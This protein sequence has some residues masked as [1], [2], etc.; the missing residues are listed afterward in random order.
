[1]LL[2]QM[3]LYFN[4]FIG[5]WGLTIGHRVSLSPLIQ[6]GDE[7]DDVPYLRSYSDYLLNSS[8]NI[9]IFP[10][11][12]YVLLLEC[13]PEKW[14]N[15]ESYSF[16]PADTYFSMPFIIVLVLLFFPSLV[17]SYLLRKISQLVYT[18][19][20]DNFKEVRHIKVGYEDLYD[21]EMCPLKKSEFNNLYDHLCSEFND[22]VK[23]NE[24]EYPPEIIRDAYIPFYKFIKTGDY[25][26]DKH[27]T[28][29]IY[30]INGR[31]LKKPIQAVFVYNFEEQEVIIYHHFTLLKES[32][33]E[34]PLKDIMETIELK[35]DLNDESL[36]ELS[37]PILK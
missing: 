36:I 9:Y 31:E 11:V 15:T 28:Y 27:Y 35:V 34:T 32:R 33:S 19:S 22:K 8:F 6:E 37:K 12:G 4:L 17:F 14:R 25:D 2:I 5:V 30:T 23:F 29:N 20:W 7:W 24:Y 18:F 26:G 21:K 16:I 1:M 13:I 3:Y 10:A